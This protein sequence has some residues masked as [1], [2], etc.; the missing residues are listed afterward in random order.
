MGWVDGPKGKGR[1]CPVHES[2][3]RTHTIGA[4]DA[5]LIAAARNALPALLRIARAAEAVLGADVFAPDLVDWAEVRELRAAL[6]AF[7]SGPSKWAPCREV[8][9]DDH[10]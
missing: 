2:T 4:E 6:A 5:A 10:G 3:K 8:G 7:E 1:V 9:R